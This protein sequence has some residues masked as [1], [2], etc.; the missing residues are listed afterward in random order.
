M[1]LVSNEFVGSVP[2][3]VARADKET[4]QD[5]MVIEGAKTSYVVVGKSGKGSFGV[6]FQA[7]EKDTENVVAIKR[8]LQ[9]PRY[10]VR[11]NKLQ[12]TSFDFSF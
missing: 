10:K 2:V 6:V 12:K 5:Q 11:T 8:V 9:D 1:K 4:P 7:L 3:V